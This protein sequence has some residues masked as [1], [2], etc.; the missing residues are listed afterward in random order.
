[1]ERQGDRGAAPGR[2]VPA[3]PSFHAGSDTVSPQFRRQQSWDAS[4]PPVRIGNRS[5]ERT[6]YRSYADIGALRIVDPQHPDRMVVAAGAPWFLAR[7]A[8][9]HCWRRSG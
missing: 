8:G 4:I 7:S 6:V 9:T 5:L 1:M 2:S 3:P